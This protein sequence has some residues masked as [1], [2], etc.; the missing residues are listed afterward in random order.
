MDEM[1]MAGVTHILVNNFD[2]IRLGT[3]NKLTASGIKNWYAFRAG[4]MKIKYSDPVCD[5]Y[6]LTRVKK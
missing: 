1:K 2:K 5:V 3:E 4:F 6:E